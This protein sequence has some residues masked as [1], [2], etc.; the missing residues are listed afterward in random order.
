[1]T[2]RVRGHV[3]VHGGDGE[4]GGWSE[5]YRHIM[6]QGAPF[7]GEPGRFTR[8]AGVAGLE[9]DV[10]DPLARIAAS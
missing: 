3:D 4:A 5:R 1:M 2:T 7:E 9:A 10:H 6:A 8:V